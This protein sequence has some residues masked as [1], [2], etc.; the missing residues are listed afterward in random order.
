MQL[1]AALYA[2][3]CSCMQLHTAMDV[4]MDAAMHASMHAAMDAASWM[5]RININIKR[6]I[7]FYFKWSDIEI[8]T[9]SI[10]QRWIHRWIQRLE[11]DPARAIQS[12]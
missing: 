9:G 5:T 11:P 8:A 3:V 2:A 7:I 10:A 1:Y 12:S 6:N 4:A